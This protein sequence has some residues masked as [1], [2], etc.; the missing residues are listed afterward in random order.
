MALVMSSKVQQSVCSDCLTYEKS[1]ID[2]NYFNTFN[3]VKAEFDLALK[4]QDSLQ[5]FLGCEDVGFRNH[6][7]KGKKLVSAEA[8]FM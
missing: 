5:R 4:D 2:F 1:R 8:Y 7:W 6:Q 3:N